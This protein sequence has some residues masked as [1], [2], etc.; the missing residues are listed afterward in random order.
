[1]PDPDQ[2]Y[3]S[4][5][6]K[7]GLENWLQLPDDHEDKKDSEEA[8]PDEPSI[9]GLEE[10]DVVTPVPIDL[11][12]GEPLKKVGQVE[13]SD[14]EEIFGEVESGEGSRDIREMEDI[15]DQDKVDIGESK[16]E[17]LI[18]V[19][20]DNVSESELESAGMEV[21]EVDFKID[22]NPEEEF[23]EL[24]LF[25]LK[26]LDALDESRD[27]GF[28]TEIPEPDDEV[29]ADDT[30]FIEDKNEISEV[31]RLEKVLAREFGDTLTGG[32]AMTISVGLVFI[33]IAILLWFI[34]PIAGFLGIS[35]VI[36]I[37][38]GISGIVSVFLALAGIHLI[39]YW[40]VHWTSNVVK[41]RELDRL[42][43][44]KRVHNPCMHL[45]CREPENI[46]ISENGSAFTE[47]EMIWQCE[48]FGV[49][50]PEVSLCVVCDKYH[51]SQEMDDEVDFETQNLDLN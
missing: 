9:F 21:P 4:S 17:D 26:F 40:W 3:K 51:P 16:D 23:Q 13:H 22:K 41:S 50:L 30:V 46:E 48:L 33:V 43:E 19:Q 31:D 37:R 20:E 18:P 1:M 42:I 39:F 11:I 27:S 10:L 14:R 6:N 44:S 45:N 2:N 15:G 24:E 36:N 49:D 29:V 7:K 38:A 25:T 47:T 12:T 35:G 28:H 34:D 32:N 8:E 5:P